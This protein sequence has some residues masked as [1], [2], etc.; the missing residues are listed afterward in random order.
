MKYFAIPLLLLSA[1]CATPPAPAASPVSAKPSRSVAEIEFYSPI[2]NEGGGSQSLQKRGSITVSKPM[3]KPASI[4][5]PLTYATLCEKQ[6]FGCRHAAVKTGLEVRI[7]EV[8]A[9]GIT[10]SGVLHTSMGREQTETEA[11]S[12][13]R[14][15]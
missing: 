2:R 12:G 5:Y 3:A 8:L 9:D 7:T 10:L 6:P 1:G 4:R 15:K 11:A 14:W 13:V